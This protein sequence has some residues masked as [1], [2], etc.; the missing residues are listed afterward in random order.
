MLRAPSQATGTEGATAGGAEA[1][2][3]GVVDADYEVLDDD[4]K[5]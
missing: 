2:G 3:D 1:P 4:E 5:K